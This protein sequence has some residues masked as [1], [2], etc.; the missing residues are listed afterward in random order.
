MFRLDG[1]KATLVIMPVADDRCN[2][3]AHRHATF[4]D[5]EYRIDLV[6][7]SRSEIDRK[8]PRDTLI[9]S[10]EDEGL[11]ITDFKEC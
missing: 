5:G 6:Y 7:R 10:A 9:K 11:T 1:Q 4:K 8:S 2:P 3:N